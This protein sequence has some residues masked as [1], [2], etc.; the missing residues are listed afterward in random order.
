[1]AA[2]PGATA[3]AMPTTA[4]SRP[5]RWRR[6][7]RSYVLGRIVKSLITL[8]LVITLSFFLLR[9]MPGN[10]VQ[11]YVQNLV[12]TQG[13]TYA[14]ATKRASSLL[15]FNPTGSLWL[16]YLQYIGSLLHGNMGQSILTPGTS[17]ASAVFASLPW[18]LFSVGMGTL[19]SFVIGTFLGVL[20]AYRRGGFLDHL[21]TNLSSL[22]HAVPNYIW[23][24]LIIV[25]FGVKLGWF[26]IT[27]TNGT[28][29][30]GVVPG[31]NLTFFGD[32]IYHAAL[33]ILVYTL[34]GLG[35]WVLMMK[36]STMQILDEDFVTVAR[37]KGLRE[38]R[39]R[40]RYV[41]RNA[42]LPLFAQ[43]ALSIGAM[44]GGSVLIEQIF[45]YQ[46][47]GYYLF[48]SLTKRDYTMTQGFILIITVSVIAANLVADLLLSRIDP[49][50]RAPGSAAR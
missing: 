38:S 34:T 37:A 45:Q 19:F 22:L 29:T 18:T 9:F 2:A 4:S 17:V 39:I 21:V 36:S 11:A 20:I 33:P 3:T 49:R 25:V 26:D 41:G 23:A 40:S 27:S 44:V 46:G 31:F 13:M 32:A 8:L 24:M 16:Q 14:D 7:H 42:V 30:P 10:P 47:V 5:S 1:M 6:L 43:F 28:L 35:G 50:V 12:S 15:A 48:D